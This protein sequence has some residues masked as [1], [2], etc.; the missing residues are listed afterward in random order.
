MPLTLDNPVHWTSGP[1]TKANLVCPVASSLQ[2][3][4]DS[5]AFGARTCPILS[6]AA[7]ADGPAGQMPMPNSRHNLKVK[8]P[9][10]SA[11]QGNNPQFGR[12]VN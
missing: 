6:L 11:I 4:R 8:M 9:W 1:R 3:E 2:V 7:A 10:T 12:L 5:S